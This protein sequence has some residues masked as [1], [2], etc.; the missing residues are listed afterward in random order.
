MP[1]SPRPASSSRWRRTACRIGERN[2]P[3][4]GR[5]ADVVES[6]R[7]LL[8][9]LLVPLAAAAQPLLTLQ[10][11]LA[12]ALKDNRSYRVAEA[13]ADAAAENVGWGEAGFLPRV[14]AN[15]GRQRSILDTR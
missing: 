12:A 3:S 14:D 4:R 11:A 15:A 7:S 6:L 10:D 2:W 13:E 9:L 5:M 1:S 8:A